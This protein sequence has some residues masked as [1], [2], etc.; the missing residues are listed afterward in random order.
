MRL[1]ATDI[2]MKLDLLF[3]TTQSHSFSFLTNLDVLF[4]CIFIGNL[5]GKRAA[6]LYTASKKRPRRKFAH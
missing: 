3:V 2:G 1:T 4:A 6:I 5:D